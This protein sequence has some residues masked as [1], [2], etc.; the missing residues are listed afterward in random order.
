MN[1]DYYAGS[2]LRTSKT[3]KV[4]RITS[5]SDNSDWYKYESQ[6][7]GLLVKTCGYEA[8]L[9]FLDGL[10]EWMK[11]I[12][13]TRPPGSYIKHQGETTVSMEAFGVEIEDPDGN[14]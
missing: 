7:V 6:L 5:I 12:S 10:P 11:E 4:Y 14:F 9:I 13:Q 3:G 8:R 2:L 1:Q